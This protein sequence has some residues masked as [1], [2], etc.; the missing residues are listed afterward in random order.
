[1]VGSWTAC[2]AADCSWTERWKKT[3]GV[4]LTFSTADNRKPPQT[5][6]QRVSVV[7][8]GVLLP[9]FGTAAAGALLVP[10]SPRVGVYQ[11][12]REI[13]NKNDGVADDLLPGTQ[14]QFAYRDSKCDST[15]A[16]TSALDLEGNVFKGA[17]VSAI[18]GAGCSASS[19]SAAEVAGGARVPMISP[20]SH[21]PELSHGKQYPYFLRTCPSDDFIAEGMIQ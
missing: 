15:H 1:M 8:L 16:L 18:I 19:V 11:A 5:A 17:G 20:S 14:L 21:S 2:S 12:I 3:S 4:G 9:M 10:W 7:R 6:L 13:N